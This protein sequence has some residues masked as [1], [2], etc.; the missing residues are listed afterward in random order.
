MR[1]R[2]R[3]G[4][5]AQRLPLLLLSLVLVACDA[6]L[7]AQAPRAATPASPGGAVADPA[8]VGAETAIAAGAAD[9]AGAADTAV[10]AVNI[11]ATAD[12]AVSAVNI[13]ATAAQTAPAPS[14]SPAGTGLQPMRHYDPY[15]FGRALAQVERHPPAPLADARVLIVPHHWLPGPLILGPLRDVA[16]GRRVRRMILV[17]PDHGNAGADPVS[18]SS[19]AWST[20]FGRVAVAGE[21]VDTLVA[22]GLARR[23]DDLLAAEHS[24]AGLVP[25]VAR[26]L[27]G[28]AVVPLVLRGDMAA[29]RVRRLAAALVPAMDDETV[30]VAAVDFAHGVRVTDVPHLNGESI[31]ALKA[32]DG[33]VVMDWGNEH[34]DS[35]ESV[36]LAMEVARRLGATR[37]EVL[38][39][40]D[41]SAFGAPAGE[42][43]TSYVVGYYR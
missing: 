8:M 28:A 20:P 11:D 7:A 37:F 5:G 6:S 14:A 21:V 1:R 25:A 4:G 43:V 26:E 3:R 41:A 27:P 23:Q 42:P 15:L 17:G 24:V 13:D 16:A 35:P 32:L 33:S 10:S 30:L 18:T 39:D 22:A 12:T 36:L 38:A 29:E 40:T 9:I 34:L 19:Q 31:A 2:A